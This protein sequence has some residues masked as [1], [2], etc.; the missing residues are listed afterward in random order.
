MAFREHA[1]YDRHRAIT[2]PR[3]RELHVGNGTGRWRAQARCVCTVCV[4]SVT[5]AQSVVG[6]PTSSSARRRCAA[7]GHG[8]RP[9]LCQRA[10]RR[11]AAGP[12]RDHGPGL[13]SP[14]HARRVLEPCRACPRPPGRRGTDAWSRLPPRVTGRGTQCRPGALAFLEPTVKLDNNPTTLTLGIFSAKIESVISTSV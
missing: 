8:P 3:R 14:T 2:V 7:Q 9:H 11:A 5:L 10:R 13:H 12:E 4:A 6:P 1:S